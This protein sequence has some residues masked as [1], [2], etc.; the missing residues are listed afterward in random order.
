MK[1]KSNFSSIDFRY[2]LTPMS[3]SSWCSASVSSWVPA[4]GALYDLEKRA[5]RIV[6][7]NSELRAEF[8]D[9]LDRI[10][11]LEDFLEESE[12]HPLNGTLA[13]RR[14]VR[15]PRREHLRD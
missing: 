3:P 11:Q 4:Y 2:H 15:A 6:N 10:N 14:S 9:R 13:P 8:A 12:P 5:D 7:L 1:T